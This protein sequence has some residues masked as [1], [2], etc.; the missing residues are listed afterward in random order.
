MS[1]KC[2]IVGLP[3][4]GAGLTLHEGMPGYGRWGAWQ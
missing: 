1:L 4:Q 2:G 3:N